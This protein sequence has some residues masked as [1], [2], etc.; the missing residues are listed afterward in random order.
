MGIKDLDNNSLKTAHAQVPME[1]F[2][3]ASEATAFAL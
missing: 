3:Q 2:S 1:T